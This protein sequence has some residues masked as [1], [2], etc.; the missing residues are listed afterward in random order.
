MTL[1][2]T[3][4]ARRSAIRI[5]ADTSRVVTRL[6]VP[7]EEGFD[8]Q[9]SRSTAVLRRVLALDDDAVQRAL[10]DVIARFEGRH[11]HLIDTFNRHAEILSDRLDP[12]YEFSPARRLLLGATFT[13][14]YAVEGAA[15][16]I[17]P[18][19]IRCRPHPRIH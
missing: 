12:G 4:Q 9:E 17:C 2:M 11:H 3:G 13:N 19:R 18:A 7:G 10:S 16:W 8:Q 5:A 15:P 14:E 1:A 6:F